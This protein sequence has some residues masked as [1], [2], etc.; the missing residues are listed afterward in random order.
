MLYPVSPL[1][2]VSVERLVIYCQT[3]SVSAAY[4][5]ALCCLLYPVVAALTS[6]FRMDSKS[7]SYS[8]SVARDEQ[9]FA[10]QVGNIGW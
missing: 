1:L 5:D 6:I 9:R 10:D 2:S 4:S 7:T 3:T 8:V